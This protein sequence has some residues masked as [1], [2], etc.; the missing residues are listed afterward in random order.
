MDGVRPYL[1]SEWSPTCLRPVR[2]DALAA[3]V[4]DEDLL[5][6]LVDLAGSDQLTGF[7]GQ[8][9]DAIALAKGDPT[10][11]EQLDPLLGRIREALGELPVGDLSRV[12]RDAVEATQRNLDAHLGPV[13]PPGTPGEVPGGGLEAHEQAGSHLI[14]RHVGKSEQDLVDRLQRENISASSSFRDLPAAEHFVA[15]TIAEHQD[16]I[17]AWVGGD[18]GRRLVI[19]ARF[20]ASTGI[21]VQR[22]ESQAEDVFSVKLVLERSDSLGIG[23]RIVTGYPTAP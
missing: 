8:T 6:H 1:A 22:G 9:D 5:A 18:G 17:D 3:A 4:A 12:E 23:Y 7:L 14:E 13:D 10:F 11:A 21:S 20:D 2:P 19:D 16:E 15:A